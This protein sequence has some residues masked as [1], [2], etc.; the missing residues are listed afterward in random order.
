MTER[1][2]AKLKEHEGLRLKPYH[3]TSGKLTIGYGRNLDDR[4]I[5]KDEAR[6]M[7]ENDITDFHDDCWTAFP[8]FRKLDPVRQDVIVQLTFNMGLG[9]VKGFKLM[10]AAIEQQN[11]T[12]AA[13]ELSNS[14][15]KAKVGKQ[16]HDD[17]TNALE[18]GQWD[19]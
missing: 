15:W 2:I 18:K 3:C 1:G 4:G 9:G 12:Q 19:R 7:L 16:R 5:S 14:E 11:W 17:L 13:W 8:W 6:A 10:I